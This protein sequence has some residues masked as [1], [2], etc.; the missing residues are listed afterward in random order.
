MT[1]KADMSLPELAGYKLATN[2]AEIQAAVITYGD[3]NSR[4]INFNV[5]KEDVA[6][7]GG[8]ND[9][10]TE[11]AGFRALSPIASSSVQAGQPATGSGSRYDNTVDNAVP[12]GTVTPEEFLATQPDT[13]TLQKSI[14]GEPT[15][16][17]YG[18][19]FADMVHFVNFTQANL[20]SGAFDSNNMLTVGMVFEERINAN[21]VLRATVTELKPFTATEAYR[22]MATEI[23]RINGTDYATTVYN[24]NQTNGFRNPEFVSD[25]TGKEAGFIVKQAG[26]YNVVGSG[27]GGLKTGESY[28]RVASSQSGADIGVKFKLEQVVEGISQPVDVIVTD[29]EQLTSHEL[30]TLTTDGRPWELAGEYKTRDYSWIPNTPTMLNDST[31]TLAEQEAKNGTPYISGLGL[32]GKNAGYY[33]ESN[34][35]NPQALLTPYPNAGLGTQIISSPVNYLRSY[36]GALSNSGARKQLSVPIFMSANTNELGL[37]IN[38]AGAQQ[39]LIGV[40]LVDRSDANESYGQAFHGISEMNASGQ[41]LQQPQLGRVAPDVDVMTDK[42]TRT[43][44]YGDDDREGKGADNNFNPDEGEK[45]LSATG[46]YEVLNVNSQTYTLSVVAKANGEGTASAKAWIDFNS[47]GQFDE[48]E[49]SEIQTFS[50]TSE[51]VLSFVWNRD[52]SLVDST[53]LAVRIRTAMDENDIANPTGIASTGEVEDFQILTKLPPKGTKDT[54]KDSQGVTQTGTVSFSARGTLVKEGVVV[55]EHGDSINS[56]TNTLDDNSI[57]GIVDTQGNIVKELETSQGKYTVSPES[58]ASKVIIKFVPNPDFTGVATGVV[59][60]STDANGLNTNWANEDTDISND[61]TILGKSTWDSLYIPEVVPL[62]T[63]SYP[64]ASSGPQG[65]PQKGTPV[66][67]I[68]ND[69]QVKSTKYTLENANSEGKV[70]AEEGTYSI[71]ETTGEV[72]FEP[73]PDYVGTA[74]G[75]KVVATY[76]VTNESGKTTTITDSASYIPTVTSTTPTGF[77]EVSSGLQGESQTEKIDFAAGNDNVPMDDKVPATFDDGKT[78]KV[79]PGVGTYTV[80]A[81]GTVTFT[82]EKTFTGEAPTVTIVRQDVNGTKATGTYTPT[83][84]AVTPVGFDATSTG[85][86]G[87]TQSGKVNFAAGDKVAPLV[88]PATFEDGT[89]EKTVPG[90]GT[91]TVAEDGTVT[92]TPE[93][94][95]TGTAKGVTVKRVDANGTPATATYT[96]TVIPSQVAEISFVDEAGNTIAE[97]VK[98]KG[99][100]NTAIKYSPKATV[101][102]LEDKGYE[103]VSST[104]EAGESSYDKDSTADQSFQLVFKEKVVTVDPNEVVPG[105]P[106]NPNNPDGPKWPES[107][108]SL[109]EEVTQTVNY[110]DENGNTVAETK[111]D[112]V[113][114]TRTATVNMV[115]GEITYSEWTAVDNDTTFDEKSSPVV[116]GY[117]ASKA[118]TDAVTGLTADS[119]DVVETIVYKPVG[120]TIITNPDGSTTEIPYT[121]DPTDPTVATPTGTIPYVSGYIPTDGNGNPLTPVDP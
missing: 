23:D 24:P 1:E 109:T 114:F 63:E 111:T 43:G 64:A 108:V 103:L 58:S 49:A 78:E 118:K 80:A 12:E 22:E 17:L 54:S 68:S 74:P 3:R 19:K 101:K 26:S 61:S 53:K 104:Y 100:D 56:V 2:Q 51:T 45:Q 70:V 50:G 66:I 93:E 106:I 82:P 119:N 35:P 47:N 31:I 90:E 57:F 39:L 20:V 95:F 99:A 42:G 55:R 11:L 96:P 92:F 8:N 110:V 40:L 71:N 59:I 112:K 27:D 73:V 81:D 29:G 67:A 116:Q 33:G 16:N 6:A 9:T 25:T 97:T 76:V 117:V 75:V 69:N 94:G 41:V 79:V 60:C 4:L 83:V 113:S 30:I 52:F 77:N 102:D 88:G 34:K 7:A 86:E 98:T 84:V 87:E 85:T 15:S 21:T 48:D 72:I 32:G 89:T 10:E 14:F 115:T 65:V 44:F 37:Y 28:S 121:N 46:T 91:Y 38:S 13:S 18:S 5:V 107:G 105:Q 36:P 120:K 62:E